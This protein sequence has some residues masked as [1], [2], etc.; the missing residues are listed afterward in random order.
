MHE[1][2]RADTKWCT[3]VFATIGNTILNVHYAKLSW[4]IQGG[5]AA[6]NLTG[7]SR[8]HTLTGKGGACK[9]AEFIELSFFRGSCKVVHM[10]LLFLSLSATLAIQ[11]TLFYK[12]TILLI[13]LTACNDLHQTLSL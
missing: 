8:E 1:P 13:F 5:S 2:Q 4:P 6:R 11:D 3:S 7:G 12:I 9:V 10:V